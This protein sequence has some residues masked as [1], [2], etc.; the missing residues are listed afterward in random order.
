M[1]RKAGPEKLVRRV[2]RGHFAIMVFSLAVLS[3]SA[4]AHAHAPG[5]VLSALGTASVDGE[6]GSG[7]WDTAARVGFP[8]ALPA[9]GTVDA[10]LYVMND[11]D[12]LYVAVV[13]FT[14][15]AQS[16]VRV[17]FDNDH[18]NVAEVGDDGLRIDASGFHDE[19]LITGPP[20]T[21]ESACFVPDSDQGGAND[22]A[23]AYIATAEQTVYELAHPLDSGDAG[24]D[25]RLGPGRT[26]GFNVEISLIISGEVFPPALVTTTFPTSPDALTFGDIVITAAGS[27]Y[28][29]ITHDDFYAAI[30]PL[31]QDKRQRGY[32]T[33]VVKTSQIG[34]SPTAEQIAAFIRNEYTTKNPKPEYVLLVGDV[35]FV[36]T[37]YRTPCSTC[38]ETASFASDLPY[39]TMDAVDYFPDVYLGRLPVNTTAE[40]SDMV[41]KILSFDACR[42][43][44]RVLL[45]GTHPETTYANGD[46][47]LLQSEG[48]AVDTAYAPPATAQTV[49][50]KINAGRLLV[51]YYGHGSPACFS[52]FFCDYQLSPLVNEELPLIIS[53]GCSTGNFAFDLYQSLGERLVLS[54]ASGAIAF[55]GATRD[56]GGYG[57]K[58]MFADG[59]YQELHKSAQIGKMF[60]AGLTAAYDAAAQA[61][62]Y[63]GPGSWTQTGFEQMAVLGDPELRIKQY[64]AYPDVADLFHIAYVDLTRLR[65]DTLT[66]ALSPR[67]LRLAEE[68]L[69]AA[70]NALDRERMRQA[71]AELFVARIALRLYA[72]FIRRE[73]RHTDVDGEVVAQLIDS[74]GAE[75][76]SIH[77]LTAAVVEVSGLNPR[78]PWL[79]ADVPPQRGEGR[80]AE[81][82]PDVSRDRTRQDRTRQ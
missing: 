16:I 61:G 53:G 46:R 64:C 43:S 13:L 41:N 12:N 76:A 62:Q 15:A 25:L 34:S 67:H 75:I 3:L 52:G 50:D 77:E 7:E 5:I 39:A 44:N 56:G 2:R 37:H 82:A 42:S 33:K 20:C 55:I 40:A 47:I 21:A 54:P 79:S 26:V 58:Y 73:A 70:E 19:V 59:L 32:L 78:F 4:T 51:A 36:P 35:D 18:D 63:V 49:F 60:H 6:L 8:V 28:L 1:R 31:A 38:G 30:Q 71:I 11:A 27:T 10:S 66:V 68:H 74:A 9:G 45:F 65:A 80:H 48:F 29:I 81:E 72:S 14:S 22:G 24:H 69:Q 23:G 57:Y 17:N